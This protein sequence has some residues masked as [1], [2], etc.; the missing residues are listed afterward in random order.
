MKR[1]LILI[2]LVLAAAWYGAAKILNTKPPEPKDGEHEHGH[3]GHGHDGD[4]GHEHEHG[5]ENRV[6][7]SAHARRNANL[8]IEEAA[9]A[10]IK[11]LLPLYGK[12]ASNEESMAHVQ[13][14][15]PGVV[16][17]VRKRLGEHVGKG[18]TLAVIESNDSL[19]NYEI[20]SELAGTVIQKDI[21]LG[22]FVKSEAT[23]F[24]IADLST[25][26]VDLAVFRQDFKKLKVGQPVEIHPG[27]GDE[28]IRDKVAYISPF[29]TEGTQTMLARCV[30]P[31]PN[32]D[33]RPGLFVTAEIVTG[34]TDAPVAVKPAAIQTLG[35]KTVVFVEEGDS[36]EAREV[37]LGARDN[38]HV[39]VLSGLLPGDRYVS[40]NS[41]IL[42]AEIGK[43]EAAHEH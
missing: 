3:G 1:Q 26:W 40:T 15:F 30:V 8:T 36:F 38:E 34:E 18:E 14:R 20:K 10:K 25:V 5:Q 23:V 28:A 37:E 7:L 16:K 43:G 41:F 42:K 29:G 21:T 35:E 11:D 13:P 17:E 31:N 33:L 32:G 27:A 24:T 39:E 12:I 4:G 9:G 2:P 6:E 19:R 22:E